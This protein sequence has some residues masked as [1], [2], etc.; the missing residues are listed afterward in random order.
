MLSQ[1]ALM[2]TSGLKRKIAS[3]A[4]SDCF[5]KRRKGCV[6]PGVGIHRR[7]RPGTFRAR[8][9]LGFADVLAAKEELSVEVGHVDGVEVDDL[10]VFEARQHQVLE[11]LAPDPAR[12]HHKH[13][14]TNERKVGMTVG[15]TWC[16]EK[17]PNAKEKAN[18][19]GDQGTYTRGAELL[20]D[21]F[22]ERAFD[23]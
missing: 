6:N 2:F 22:S 23:V 10:D 4:T 16:T 12:T 15:L 20:D 9:Y 21:F 13:L 11:Q 3:R 14:K 8:P 1:Y 5:V 7:V 19:E 17:E 18:T